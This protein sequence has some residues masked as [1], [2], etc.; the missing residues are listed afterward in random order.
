MVA[1]CTSH[2]S[3]LTLLVSRLCSIDEGMSNERGAAGGMG[4]GDN[5]S[6][7]HFSHHMSHMIL[8]GIETSVVA[9]GHWNLPTRPVA[10]GFYGCGKILSWTLR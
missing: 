7:C 5:L 9:A 4:T 3:L 10:G 8:H 1:N 2:I 6:Q